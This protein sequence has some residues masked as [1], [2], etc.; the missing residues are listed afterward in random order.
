MSAS[1]H[2]I[3]RYTFDVQFSAKAKAIA[4]QDSLSSLFRRRLMID[5]D[6]L[7]QQLLP[8]DM[9]AVLDTLELDLGTVL[10]KDMET[11][12]PLKLL[13]ALEKALSSILRTGTPGSQHHL[14]GNIMVKTGNERLYELL[15]YYLLS[16]AM[17]WW[18]SAAEREQPDQAIFQLAA[19]APALLAALIRKLGQ[20]QYVRKRIAWQFSIA[21]IQQIVNVLEPAEAEFIL[22]YSREVLHIQQRQQ[23]LQ[24]ESKALERAVWLFV[25]TYLLTDGGSNFSRKEFVRSHLTQMAHHFNVDYKYGNC[26]RNGGDRTWEGVLL[27]NIYPRGH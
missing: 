11:Q 8:E 13:E 9:V 23:V 1:H 4:L 20:V 15:E 22:E 18:A 27:F 7:L 10:Y 3:R 26:R 5:M 16:G 25:L 12:L 2:I 17:P 24:T 6:E 19:G 14:S 21:A